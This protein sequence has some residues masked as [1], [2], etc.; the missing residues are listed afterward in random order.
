[1]GKSLIEE[2]A[3]IC[4]EAGSREMI[5]SVFVSNKLAFRFYESLGAKRIQELEFM[6]LPIPAQ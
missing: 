6:Y 3:A 1:V 4:R 2:A 5:W